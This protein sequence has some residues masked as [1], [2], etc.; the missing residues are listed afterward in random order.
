MHRR[1]A[2]DLEAA[3]SSVIILSSK[4]ITHAL[5]MTSGG[6]CSILSKSKTTCTGAHV[7]N[8]TLVPPRILTSEAGNASLRY[9]K[10]CKSK[11]S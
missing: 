4:G 10:E 3:A 1:I 8:E 5:V 2:F 11:V 9:P 6:L 7:E